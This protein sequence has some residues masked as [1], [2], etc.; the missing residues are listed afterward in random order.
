MGDVATSEAR[1]FAEK[2]MG[3][4]D[5]TK[6]YNERASRGTLS[7][8]GK[9]NPEDSYIPMQ[10]ADGSIRLVTGKEITAYKKATGYKGKYTAS[11]VAGAGST[12]A[13]FAQGE[14]SSGSNY[15]GGTGVARLEA[16]IQAEIDKSI[17]RENRMLKK[18]GG[19]E[20]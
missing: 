7:D 4:T 12:V 20:M 15:F 14:G 13:D 18:I 5:T 10:L 17:N 11:K 2:G 1:T 19:V 16:L 6:L 3:I 9:L 8:I